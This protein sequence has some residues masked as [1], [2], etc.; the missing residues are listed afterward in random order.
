MGNSKSTATFKYLKPGIMPMENKIKILHL[1]DSV[2]DSELIFSL[3]EKGNIKCDYFLVENEKDF[4]KILETE[5]IDIILCDYNLPDYNGNDALKIVREKYS[6][7]PFIFVS[8]TIGEDTAIEAMINGATDYVLKNKMERLVPAIKRALK[9]HELAVKNKLSEEFLVISE[10]RYRRLFEA[11][12]DG[13][14]ILDAE[15]G[16]IVDVNPFLIELLG[17]THDEFLG[18]AIWDI[19][20]FKDVFAN[21]HKFLELQETKY[22]RYE[23]LP[24][25]TANGE[26]V[27]VEFVSNVYD[28]NGEEVIQCN[29]RDITKRKKAEEDI[30]NSRNLLQRIIDLLP[31]RIFWKDNNLNFLGCNKIFAEDAGKERSADLIGKDDFQMNWKEQAE[32]YRQDDLNVINSGIP[33]LNYE[34]IQTTPEGEKIWLNTSKVPLTNFQGTIIG[35]LGSYESITKRKNAEKELRDSEEKYRSLVENMGEGVGITDENERFI[36]VNPA[37]E[38]I[39]GVAKGGLNSLGLEN[40]TKKEKFKNLTDRTKER[41]KGKNEVYELEIHLMDGSKKDILVTATPRFD[42]NVFKGTFGI[43]SDITEQKIAVQEII[44]A[45]EKAEEMSRLKMNF[46][47][48]MSHEIRTPLNGIL[49]FADIL[50]SE[51]KD[52]EHLKFADRINKSGYRLMETLDLILSFAKL[53]AE[54]QDVFYSNVNLKDV[55]DEIL[56]SFEAVANGKN[57]FL[58]LIENE[59]NMVS[60]LDERFLRQIMNNLLNNA[61]KYTITG[62]IT[63]TLSKINSNLIIKVLDTGIGIAKE[64]QGIIFDEFR[65]ESE[66]HGRNFQG[67]GLGLSITKRFVELLNGTIEVNS[68]VGI[69]STFTL[70]FPFINSRESNNIKPSKSENDEEL[71]LIIPADKDKLTILLVEDDETSRD[72]TIE[73]IKDY[74]NV[75]CVIDGKN[76]L[77]LINKKVYDIVLMD[78][79]LGV[80]INGIEVTQIIKKIKEYEKIPIVALTAF[81]LP[82]DKEEF[83]EGGCTHY[84]GKPFTKNQILKL[85]KTLADNKSN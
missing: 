85:L 57:L 62:G 4:L 10:T 19:G 6:F 75:E 65:Q 76:A 68:D 31:I 40:F 13:I 3:I 17:Y 9:E 39:F 66:G 63:V 27:Y 54:K 11:A 82:G 45:K 35:I 14:L 64:Y 69:G 36:F 26:K 46:L 37:G 15:T 61:I 1:E 16:M 81:A 79:N 41:L 25:K 50:K 67:T 73:S 5:T 70:T 72:F 59:K 21:E 52:P 28:V 47:A 34:E 78:I 44:K 83:I 22:I 74:Y 80:G 42:D 60:Y 43:F 48:N 33:K 32:I 51:L 18:K 23:D 2:N 71:K 12:R 20:L 55:I 77:E 8:G 24:L 30:I 29:I 58:R 49:G 53:E 84:L 7:I 38:K 56:K